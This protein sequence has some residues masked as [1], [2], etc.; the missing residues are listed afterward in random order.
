MQFVGFVGSEFAAF[1]GGTSNQTVVSELC[2]WRSL[3]GFLGGLWTL[4][5]HRRA[6]QGEHLGRSLYPRG[7]FIHFSRCIS[8]SR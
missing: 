7:A 8:A 5:Q 6:F 3:G 2:G 1:T 4:R